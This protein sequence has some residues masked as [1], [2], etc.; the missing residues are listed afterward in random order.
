ML[1][2]CHFD[3]RVALA[4]VFKEWERDTADNTKASHLTS[5]NLPI[6]HFTVVCLM[7]RP[8]DGSEAGVDLV[9]IQTSLLL[10]CCNTARTR[11]I[12]MTKAARSVSKQ[13]QLQPRCHPKAGSLSRH[14]KTVYCLSS[15]PLFCL[16]FV[17]IPMCKNIDRRGF[18]KA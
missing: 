10:L 1:P 5:H 6:D 8:L 7:T 4:S 2:R 9:L 17:D 11:C 15:D 12:Y 14:C 13:G 3:D 18:Q 16:D